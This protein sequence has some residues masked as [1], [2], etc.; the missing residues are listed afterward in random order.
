MST[1]FT[2]QNIWTDT[3]LSTDTYFE[4]LR[5]REAKIKQTQS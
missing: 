1:D 4:L 2:K 3:D 5:E